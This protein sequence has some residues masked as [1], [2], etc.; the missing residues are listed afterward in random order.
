ME[1]YAGLDVSL[2]ETSL[3]IVDG[4]GKI[5]HE[6]KVA[7]EPEALVGYLSSPDHHG[8]AHRAGSRAVVAVAPRRPDAGWL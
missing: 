2:N 7:S 1:H 6:T 5:I 3:C 4:A 8:C